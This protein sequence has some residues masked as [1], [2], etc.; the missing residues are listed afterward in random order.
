MEL[1]N[2]RLTAIKTML[3]MLLMIQLSLMAIMVKGEVYKVGDSSGWVANT[4]SN[5][6]NWASSKIFRVHDILSKCCFE[7]LV[8]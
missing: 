4:N 5:Y 8:V 6:S 7:S 3:C 1:F 2:E